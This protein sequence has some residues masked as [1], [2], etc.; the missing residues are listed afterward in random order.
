MALNKRRT[1]A[2]AC[3]LLAPLVLAAPPTTP[4]TPHASD[5]APVWCA[6]CSSPGDW[7]SGRQQIGD[8]ERSELESV[9]LGPVATLRVGE[10]DISDIEGITDPSETYKLTHARTRRTWTLRFAD[11]RGKTGTLTFTLPPALTVFGVDPQDGRTSPG[12]G[13][14]LYKEWRL[15][16]PV[17]GT[18]IFKAGAARGARIRLVLQGHGNACT[19]ASDFR[20]WN[21][22]VSTRSQSFSFYG[23]TAAASAESPVE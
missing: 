7:Y 8:M 5:A 6:C 11:D 4:P 22:Q 10:A 18:G 17:T 21:L 9:K 16:A 19:S 15:E 14:L 20:H 12:G 3:V 13:P 23:P 1:A 2:L